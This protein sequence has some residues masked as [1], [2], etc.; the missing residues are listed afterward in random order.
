MNTLLNESDLPQGVTCSEVTVTTTPSGEDKS[1]YAYEFSVSIS[2]SLERDFDLTL[3]DGSNNSIKTAKI[4]INRIDS[5]PK[6]GDSS[7]AALWITL[8]CMS[9]AAALLMR[10]REHN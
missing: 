5:Q 7:C 6:T 3:I 4:G 9:G 2:A 8:L 10:R 1:D